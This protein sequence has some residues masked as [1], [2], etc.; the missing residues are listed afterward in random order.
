MP[1]NG[2]VVPPNF[3]I[4]MPKNKMFDKFMAE[5][6]KMKDMQAHVHQHFWWLNSKENRLR[7]C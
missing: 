1:E 2:Y 7:F 3:I 5:I 6:H 4:Q